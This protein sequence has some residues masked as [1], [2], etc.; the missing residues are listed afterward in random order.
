MKRIISCILSCLLLLQN[1]VYAQALYPTKQQVE[2][3][4]T[5][6]NNRANTSKNL[7]KIIENKDISPLFAVAIFAGGVDIR[8]MEHLMSLLEHYDINAYPGDHILKLYD[9]TV[10]RYDEYCVA[11]EV[12]CD[13]ADY[14]YNNAEKFMIKV[15]EKEPGIIDYYEDYLKAQNNKIINQEIKILGIKGLPIVSYETSGNAK[16]L[17]EQSCASANIT[18]K[19]FIDA[20]NNLTQLGTIVKNVA[21]DES[22][23]L[24]LARQLSVERGRYLTA[25]DFELIK[26]ERN[27]SKALNEL[28]TKYSKNYNQASETY[29]KG[30]ERAELLYRNLQNNNALTRELSRVQY[31]LT[32]LELEYLGCDAQNRTLEN[33]LKGGEVKGFAPHGGLSFAVIASLFLLTNNWMKTHNMAQYID[34][35]TQTDTDLQAVIENNQGNLFALLETLPAKQRSAAFNYI[36]EGYYPQFTEQTRQV[37]LTLA[38]LDN[39]DTESQ[40]KSIGQAIELQFDKYYKSA[41]NILPKYLQ[42]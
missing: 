35:Q 5:K 16:L 27:R 14:L 41:E 31:K 18:P 32:K 25:L 38:I 29:F 17:F 22:N 2:N 1:F 26:Y 37:L 23:L 33:L 34:E 30:V 42:F 4:Y 6:V 11:D 7:K 24:K 15:M 10:K 39:N 21:E 36:A 28:I 19:Q 12:F 20:Y 9:A 13:Y 8:N 3:I 40:N